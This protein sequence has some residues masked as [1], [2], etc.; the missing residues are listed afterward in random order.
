[1]VS[2]ISILALLVA[3]VVVTPAYSTWWWLTKVI[4]TEHAHWLGALS[5]CLLLTLRPNFF[6]DGLILLVSSFVMF[7]PL[8]SVIH[9][10]MKSESGFS[11]TSVLSLAAQ[12]RGSEQ[13]LE[14]QNQGS[15][16]PIDFYPARN[17]ARD[18]TAPLVITI[19]GGGWTNGS[20]KD[21]P[22]LNYFL[23]ENGFNVAAISHRLVPSTTFP[24]PLED[25]VSATKFILN[26]SESLKIDP[27]KIFFLGRSAGGQLA[28]LASMRLR[29]ENFQIRGVIALYSPFDLIWGYE[30]TRSWH[31]INGKE[32]IGAYLGEPL[33]VKSQSIYQAASP[34]FAASA[35]TPPHLLI[36]G[37]RDDLV[38][39]HHTRVFA[40]RLQELGCQIDKVE[41]GWASHGFDYFF[42]SPHTRYIRKKILLFL[43]LKA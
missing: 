42:N 29:A 26:Q 37:I 34:L 14:F 41:L 8:A 20:Q 2:F 6:P 17:L 24:G 22:E 5:L 16:L 32:S 11:L 7:I 38:S 25:V 12:K 27:S 4:I 31:I 39:I 18:K 13:N 15:S 3:A 19:H 40:Q 35:A 36:H 21:L 10:E 43:G 23:A 33:S 1:M 9:Q 28:S 30:N